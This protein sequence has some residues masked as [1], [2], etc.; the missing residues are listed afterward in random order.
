MPQTGREFNF[1][2]F[3]LAL[4]TDVED[5]IRACRHHAIQALLVLLTGDVFWIG[6][7]RAAFRLNELCAIPSDPESLTLRLTQGS[8]ILNDGVDHAGRWF[9]VYA[10]GRTVTLDAAHPTLDRYDIV[11]LAP[12]RRSSGTVNREAV[13]ILG[14]VS[15]T[16]DHAEY[17]DDFDIT[18][19][20]GDPGAAA[21]D[22]YR[23]TAH[24]AVPPG[25]IPIS[26]VHVPAGATAIA[27]EHLEDLREIFQ[28]R[29]M[30]VDQ[31]LDANVRH[32]LF[33]IV[34]PNIMGVPF[35]FYGHPDDEV[36]PEDEEYYQYVLQDSFFVDKAAGE[37][38]V[39]KYKHQDNTVVTL[40]DP[41][42]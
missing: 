7:K 17:Y 19:R 39:L 10:N 40:S 5:A 2:P 14:N 3:T 12:V 24:T 26:L 11:C 6:H 27:L 41:G 38:G 4:E 28:V 18:V 29:N 31:T 1:T 37:P 34:P 15:I 25:L 8:A 32:L 36:G 23:L 9:H 16:T 21:P 30:A 35:F 33:N 20:K 13:D 22:I 42:A